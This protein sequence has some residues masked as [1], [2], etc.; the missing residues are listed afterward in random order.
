M[1]VPGTYQVLNKQY[2][3]LFKIK[4][5]YQNDIFINKMKIYFTFL[6]T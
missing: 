5:I 6:K 4:I 2:L 3:L 1:N